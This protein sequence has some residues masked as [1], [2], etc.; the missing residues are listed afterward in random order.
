MLEVQNN[1]DFMSN[2]CKETLYD[3]YTIIK[4]TLNIMEESLNASGLTYL[5]ANQLGMDERIAMVKYENGDVHAFIN[6]IIS[7]Y[8]KEMFLSREKDLFDGKEYLVPRKKAIEVT[9]V[10]K[11]GHPKKVI[12]KEGA[13]A[14]LQNLIE[15]L[16]GVFVS[17]YGLEIIPEFDGASDEEK[18]EVIKMYIDSLVKKEDELKKETENNPF[19]KYIDDSIK[20]LSQK[21]KE[22]EEKA[23]QEKVNAV[24]NRAQRRWSE[25]VIKK[26]QKMQEQQKE[27]VEESTNENTEVQLPTG[28]TE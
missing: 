3:D 10:N 20:E 24:P 9:F 11:S 19:M 26:L 12:Y 25:K 2:R 18:E 1:K 28:S 21:M 23:I 16:E 6:P 14:L 22:E 4:K 27:E 17:D 5:T 8:S 15:L 7:D 13:S